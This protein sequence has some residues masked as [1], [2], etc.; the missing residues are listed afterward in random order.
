MLCRA[1]YGER[2][3]ELE[4]ESHEATRD[5]VPGMQASTQCARIRCRL[6]LSCLFVYNTPNLRPRCE[7]RIKFLIPCQS[8]V[9]FPACHPR[10]WDFR[11]GSSAAVLGC[12][13]TLRALSPRARCPVMYP[14]ALVFP[15][16]GHRTG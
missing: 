14:R 16:D 8:T 11:W 9:W 12:T 13:G 4:A 15:R 6:P 5:D 3:I 1:S 7:I 10:W 2:L